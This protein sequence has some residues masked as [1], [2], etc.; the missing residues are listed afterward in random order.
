ML[1]EIFGNSKRGSRI[2]CPY[3]RATKEKSASFDDKKRYCEFGS[4]KVFDGKNII[5]LEVIMI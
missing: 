2:I 3:Q 5:T 4:T 1:D